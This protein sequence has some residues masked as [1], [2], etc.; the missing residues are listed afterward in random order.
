MNDDGEFFIG[1]Q[2]RMPPRT[3]RK[4]TGL[5]VGVALVAGAAGWGVAAMQRTIGAATWDYAHVREFTGVLTAHPAP[6]L[7]VNAPELCGTSTLLLVQPNKF[8]FDRALARQLDGQTVRLR[9]T[10]L[11]R[12]GHAMLDV[13]PGSVVAVERPGLAH[14][15]ASPVVELGEHVLRGEIVDSKCFLGAMNP[16]VLKPHRA[17][18]IRCISGGI[19]PILLVRVGAGQAVYY[20]LVGADGEPINGDVL[21]FVAEP[22]EIRGVVQRR[23]D[24]LVLRAPPAAIQRLR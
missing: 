4:L 11:C 6:S 13:V 7:R 22:V 1:W 19:P 3:G 2:A 21:D 12:E 9:G 15:D 5:T 8:G 20:L 17:C 18:A 14:V 23:G 24:L 16:G 10:V